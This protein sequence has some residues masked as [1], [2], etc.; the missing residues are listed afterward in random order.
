LPQPAVKIVRD[1]T[2]APREFVAM[3]PDS[4]KVEFYEDTTLT[5]PIAHHHLHF[6]ST[7][8]DAERAWWAKALGAE[9]K[10]EGGRTI[11]SNPGRDAELHQGRHARRETQGRSLDHTGVN[12]KNVNEY[13][14]KL[15]GMGIMCERPMGANTAIAMVTDPAGV[16]IEIIRAWKP[17]EANPRVEGE[18]LAVR[19]AQETEVAHI[20]GQDPIRAE[21]VRSCRNCCVRSSLGLRL[22]S[23]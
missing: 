10:Q 2:E 17:D 7:D 21:P 6:M 1:G 3:F 13:C 19:S 18:G 12:V 11:T 9:T 22:R 5:T 23:A 4:V 14:T 20:N 16:R 8:P 15:A